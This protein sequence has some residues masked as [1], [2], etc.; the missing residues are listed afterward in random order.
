MKFFFA[1]L[2][3]LLG[4]AL[5][6]P[7]GGDWGPWCAMGHG[8][9]FRTRRHS[10]QETHVEFQNAGRATV[11][12]FKVRDW[13]FFFSFRFFFLLLS[14]VSVVCTFMTCRGDFEV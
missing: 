6:A 2:L 13:R 8:L 11:R 4:L 10:A 5:A 7:P 14:Y 9:S 12:E 1:F 3:G